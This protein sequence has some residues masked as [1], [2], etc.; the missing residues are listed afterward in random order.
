MPPSDTSREV[1]ATTLLPSESLSSSVLQIRKRATEVVASI[2]PFVV[3]ADEE[4]ANKKFQGIL[5]EQKLQEA[6]AANL[7]EAQERRRKLAGT[8]ERSPFVAVHIRRPT[9]D[10][11]IDH[12]CMCSWEFIALAVVTTNCVRYDDPLVC[13]NKL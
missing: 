10:S 7:Q 13:S 2:F 4:G 3:A 5:I 1:H 6:R 8:W 12:R 11:G 9:H